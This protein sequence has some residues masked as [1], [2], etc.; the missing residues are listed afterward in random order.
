MGAGLGRAAWPVGSYGNPAGAAPPRE[1]WGSCKVASRAALA[2]M[3]GTWPLRCQLPP[4][5]AVG[6]PSAWVGYATLLTAADAARASP[7]GGRA[8]ACSWHAFVGCS[9]RLPFSAPLSSWCC[10]VAGATCAVDAKASLYL[11]LPHT[12]SHWSQPLRCCAAG[13]DCA[14][15]LQGRPSRG[16]GGPGPRADPHQRGVPG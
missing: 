9:W 13:A 14:G 15:C 7:K 11:Q 8:L 12:P 6:A 1:N 4:A 2:A 16:R 5:P 3:P 10:C